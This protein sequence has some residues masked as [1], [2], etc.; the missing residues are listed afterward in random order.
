MECRDGTLRLLRRSVPFSEREKTR[1]V[2]IAG[3][4]TGVSIKSCQ[5]VPGY[6]GFFH[7][8]RDDLRIQSYSANAKTGLHTW[9]KN[10]EEK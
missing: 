5:S 10:V 8:K 1:L 2:Q 6:P 7:S 4:S 3:F 9:L